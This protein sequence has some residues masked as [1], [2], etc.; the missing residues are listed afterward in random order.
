MLYCIGKRYEKINQSLKALSCNVDVVNGLCQFKVSQEYKIEGES[1]MEVYYKFPIPSGFSVNN[2]TITIGEKVI[3]GLL[4]KKSTAIREYK[5]A[6]AK[7]DSGFLLQ[8]CDDSSLECCLGNVTPGTEIKTHID[9][10][11][12]MKCELNCNT[13]RMI[14][15]TTIAE[16]YS[17]NNFQK[18][19]GNVSHGDVKYSSTMNFSIKMDGGIK[20]ITVGELLLNPNVEEYKFTVNPESLNKDIII[21]IERNLSSSFAV[22]NENPSVN[23]GKYKYAT[24]VNLI[25]EKDSLASISPEEI[26]YCLVLDRSGSMYNDMDVLREA[27]V[28]ALNIIPNGSMIDLYIFDDRFER[29]TCEFD[30]NTQEYKQKAIKWISELNSRGG[31]EILPV[32]TDVY[33]RMKGKNGA[34]IFL[35]DGEVFNVDEIISLIKRNPATRVFTIGIGSNVSSQL[36]NDMAEAG[37]GTSEFAKNCKDTLEFKVAS[38]VLRA[39]KSLHFQNHYKLEP[40]TKGNYE[41]IP[42]E[43][44][45]LI[46]NYNNIVYLFSEEPV[47]AV[48]FNDVE[49]IVEQNNGKFD[50]INHIAAMKYMKQLQFTNTYTSKITHLNNQE[51]DDLK[52]EIIQC[53][54][55]NNVLSK[56]TGFIGVEVRDTKIIGDTELENVPLQCPERSVP[57]YMSLF[58]SS[59][60]RSMGTPP[61]ND[62]DEEECMECM[63]CCFSDD[64]SFTS[65]T[66]KRSSN[67]MENLT[68]VLSINKDSL[69]F[70][71]SGNLLISMDE[72]SLCDLLNSASLKI[73]D[74]VEILG[75]GLF[76]ILVLGSNTEKWVLKSI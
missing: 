61:Y 72:V 64:F 62:D 56:Y 71:S 53:S 20:R 39:Q 69:K 51:D 30:G 32:L 57:K 19:G 65:N 9:M 34:I 76:K 12:E 70:T 16:K 1:Q 37:M 21:L 5:E 33:N 43:L 4:K 14:I 27:A 55:D 38:T 17:P 73:G 50:S 10:C 2:F 67:K 18:Q 8:Q 28:T 23:N 60:V 40:A 54:L 3:K 41:L 26:H 31:T 58:S 36:I 11:G 52:D 7:G 75:L 6:I 74:V 47:T 45:P 66:N 59:N 29:F 42:K 15:P 25:P 68:P 35:S 22:S 24:Q 48:K 46:E 44:P 49:M 63:E 13:Y